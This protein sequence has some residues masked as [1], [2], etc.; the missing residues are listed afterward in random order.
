MDD[1]K[2]LNNSISF[3]LSPRQGAHKDTS[4]FQTGSPGPG[5]LDR[6]DPPGGSSALG[7]CAPFPS[8]PLPPFPL[9]TASANAFVIVPTPSP[10]VLRIKFPLGCA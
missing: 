5:F 1:V 3:G 6:L 8:P 9:P 10:L 7:V 2:S 4:S